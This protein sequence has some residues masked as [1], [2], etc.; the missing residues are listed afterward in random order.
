VK[1][2]IIIANDVR[3]TLELES[4]FLQREGFAVHA[5]GNG[6]EALELARKIQPDLLLLE[7]DM[8]LLSGV[9]VCETV[10]SDTALSS[11]PVLIVSDSDSTQARERCRRAGCSGFVPRTGGAEQLLKAVAEALRVGVRQRERVALKIQVQAG[12]HYLNFRGEARDLSTGGMRFESPEP[13]DAELPV[14]VQFKLPGTKKS[15][16]AT[17]RV[18]RC[19]P[20]DDLRFLIAAHFDSIDPEARRQ[21]ERFLQ[22]SHASQAITLRREP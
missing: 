5:A 15:I 4:S 19:S 14:V 17:V 20:C 2:R 3:L 9:E 6:R 7:Y 8:P 21:I 13:I 22:E 16:T 1:R 10:R 12:S 11:L 18:T